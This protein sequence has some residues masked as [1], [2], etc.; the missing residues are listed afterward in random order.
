MGFGPG[1]VLAV[2]SW[3]TSW[4]MNGAFKAM[5][6]FGTRYAFCCF[7]QLQRSALWVHEQ[8]AKNSP[9]FALKKLPI[10][11]KSTF[12]E[13]RTTIAEVSMLLLSVLSKGALHHRFVF[14]GL[15]HQTTLSFTTCDLPSGGAASR[16]LRILSAWSTTGNL[17]WQLISNALAQRK[18]RQRVAISLVEMSRA[19][20]KWNQM[21]FQIAYCSFLAKGRGAI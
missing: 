5:S 7:L 14:H 19:M 17:H 15:C 18:V 6:L 12:W 16:R 3:S 8:P 1:Y 4:G 2:N 10:F 13:S 20:V 11:L 21:S 9:A